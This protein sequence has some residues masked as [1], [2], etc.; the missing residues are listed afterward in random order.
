MSA[1]KV[2]DMRGLGK[3]LKH[4]D[5]KYLVLQEARRSGKVKLDYV[6][7]KKNR[8]DLLTKTVTGAQFL[9][10]RRQ[11]GLTL[12]EELEYSQ[13]G[14]QIV[15]PVLPMFLVVPGESGDSVCTPPE[16]VAVAEL[17][18]Q[19]AVI[20]GVALLAGVGAA[21]VWCL[22]CNGLVSGGRSMTLGHSPSAHTQR[23]QQAA[24]EMLFTLASGVTGARTASI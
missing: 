22:Q 6:E 11:I 20:V 10:L 13:P 12:P 9:A 14:L 3:G 4:L 24:T 2:T 16:Q 5:C 19:R 7:T 21:E 1:L 15:A 17:Q 23:L 8:A 18:P